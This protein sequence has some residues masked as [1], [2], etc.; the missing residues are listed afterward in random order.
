MIAGKCQ[1]CLELKPLLKKSHIIPKFMY[2]GLFDP[3]HKI[4]YVS[5]ADVT[6]VKLISD[7]LYEPNLLCK[8][9]DNSVIG[10]LETY[11]RIMLYGGNPGKSNIPVFERRANQHGD[12]SI[13][14]KNL[15]YTKAKL[16]LLSVLWRAHI[17]KLPFFRNVD[18]GPVAEVLRGMIASYNAADVDDFETLV[19]FLNRNTKRPLKSILEPLRVK[20]DNNISYIFYI[21]GLIYYFN[22]S[23]LNKYELY[24]K[25]HITLENSMR[26]IMLEDDIA[27]AFFDTLFY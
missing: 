6:N 11:M 4:R 9:C 3:K 21:N 17:S 24:S 16:F 22:I 15:D 13:I 25:G 20:K 18:L 8:E 23:Q 12:K 26:V 1:L 5:R 14:I 27:E 19:I 10:K 7:G 2:H